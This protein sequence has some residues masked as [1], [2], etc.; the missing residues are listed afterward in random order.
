MGVIM[1]VMVS[2]QSNWAKLDFWLGGSVF[3][4][5]FLV[6]QVSQN[7]DFSDEIRI[8][9]EKKKRER[10]RNMVIKHDHLGHAKRR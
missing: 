4:K 7:L 1:L 5:P 3:R 10:L 6:Y 2:Q 9:V 8:L